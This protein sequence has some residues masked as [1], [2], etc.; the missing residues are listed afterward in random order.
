MFF[1]LKQFHAETVYKLEF[2][3]FSFLFYNRLILYDKEFVNQLILKY[4]II[5]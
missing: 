4:K 2:D 1:Y 3:L 5:E